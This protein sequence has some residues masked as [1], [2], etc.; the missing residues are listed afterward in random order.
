LGETEEK[1]GYNGNVELHP[2]TTIINSNVRINV[3]E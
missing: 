3:P 1:D 2:G